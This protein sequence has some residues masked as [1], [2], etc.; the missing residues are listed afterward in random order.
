MCNPS[1]RPRTERQRTPLTGIGKRVERLG[2]EPDRVVVQAHVAR[3][4][5]D[6]PALARQPDDLRPLDG[7]CRRRAGLGQLSNS[8]QLVRGQRADLECDGKTYR[9]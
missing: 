4:G 8:T 7:A 9:E 2:V 3:D 5:R 1:D 6:A